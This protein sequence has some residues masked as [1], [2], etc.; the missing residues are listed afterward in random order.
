MSEDHALSVGDSI[1]QYMKTALEIDSE[2][3]VAELIGV[4][5]TT[6]DDLLPAIETAL[7]ASKYAEL[8]VAAHSLKGCAA[9]IGAV[10]ISGMAA[11]LEQ[12]ALSSDAGVCPDLVSQLKAS[13]AA[14]KASL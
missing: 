10:A 2:E 7:A 9:N 1:R 14:L 3:D 11:K 12:A 4:F 6:V 13:I 5:L 8:R